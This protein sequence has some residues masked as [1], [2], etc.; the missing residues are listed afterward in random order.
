MELK[1]GVPI[2]L[3]VQQVFKVPCH[4]PHPVQQRTKTFPTSQAFYLPSVWKYYAD[5]ATILEMRGQVAALLPH[6]SLHSR[7]NEQRI[8]LQ[9]SS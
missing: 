1:F 4:V 9:N 3:E 8:L 7:E 2:D 5:N 6:K